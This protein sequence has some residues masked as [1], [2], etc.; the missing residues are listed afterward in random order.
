MFTGQRLIMKKGNAPVDSA[1][2]GFEGYCPIIQDKRLRECNYGDF[3]Q[4]NED[5]VNYYDYIITQFPNGESL[6]DVENRIRDFI[7]YLKKEYDNKFVSIMAHKAPQ[8]AL[9]VILNGKTWEEAIREDWRN[10]KSWQPGW[11]YIIR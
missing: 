8:L 2:L 6:K 3:N 1:H 9:E 7:D 10:S 5:L 11:E 4:K